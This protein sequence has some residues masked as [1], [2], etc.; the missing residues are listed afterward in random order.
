[1]HP[2]LRPPSTARSRTRR[3]AGAVLLASMV[4]GAALVTTNPA[5]AATATVGVYQNNSSSVTLHGSWRT[6]KSTHELGGSYATLAGAGYATLTFR[7]NGITWIT[8]TNA[9]AG[10]ADVY[11]DGKKTKTVD[12]YAKTTKFQQVVY[13][14]TGLKSGTHTIKV[15]RTGKKNSASKGRNLMV[16]AFQVLDG[17]A[18]STPGGLKTSPIKTGAKVSWAKSSGTGLT[19]YRLYRQAGSATAIRVASLGASTTSFS[20]VGL[21]PGT[22]YSYRV[23]AT[24]SSGN[25]SA[26]SAAATFATKSGSVSALARASCGGATATVAN[27]TQLMAALAAARPGSVIS[28]KPGTYSGKYHLT[29]VGTTAAPVA[30][31]GPR[32]AVIDG[33]NPKADGG[34]KVNHSA[35]VLISGLSVTRSQKGISVL[36]SRAVV[37]RNTHV[38]HIG[39]EGIHL[40]N[41]TTDSTVSGNTID[42]TGLSEPGFGEG[43]YVGSAK[44][45]WCA[46]TG[47][48]P[49][50]SDRNAVTGNTI[51]ATRAE[52]IEVKEGTRD[53]YITANTVDGSSTDALNRSV[54]KVKGNGWVVSSNTARDTP[55]DGVIVMQAAGTDGGHNA[56]VYGNTFTGHITGFGV[57]LPDQ[58]LGNVVGCEQKVPSSAKRLTQGSCQL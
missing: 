55:E 16:D 13:K 48:Q 17:A 26:R 27:R 42:H 46:Y 7:G 5:A 51:S 19:G 56:I 41:N 54:I 39:D 40:K 35:H 2:V 11:L 38:H 28:L 3:V 22:R 18:P 45:N 57:R 50:R 30:I 24:N 15:V 49:D 20:D 52:S 23:E 58:N 44:N 29:A 14:A 33:G 1:V 10:R 36:N 9:A 25:V 31:C 4:A 34:I 53:G 6:V 8:R 12:L 37:I 21:S 47:C 32:S 43:V